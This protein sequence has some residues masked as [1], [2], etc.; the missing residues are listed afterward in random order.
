MEDIY[1]FSM[2]LSIIAFTMTSTMTPGP[3]NIML[4]SSGLTFGYKRTLSHMSGVIFGYPI[5]LFFI[6]F[7]LGIVFEKFPFILPF[8]KIVGSLYLLWMAY[9][10]ATN[11]NEYDTNNIKGEPF[12]FL[13][14]ALFQWINP[15]GWIMGITAISIFITSTQQ[16]YQQVMILSSVYLVSAIISTNVWTMGGVLLKNILKNQRYIS[17]FNK[18]MALLLVVSVVPFVIE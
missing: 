12:S 13:Q 16:R 5:M 1:T 10:I 2:L 17:V 18:M 3:N 8:L 9:K 14:A 7:G 4:L 15:K 11:I 6:G